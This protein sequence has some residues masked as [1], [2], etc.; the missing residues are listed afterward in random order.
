MTSNFLELTLL[1]FINALCVFFVVT[2]LANSL[3]D[4]QYRWFVT[5][6]VFL[7]G[8]VDFSYL[9]Y[10]VKN[11][12]LA[13]FFYQ[14]N[15]AFVAAFFFAAYVFY[16][17]YFLGINK[18]IFK[19]GVLSASI[20]FAYL[21]LITTTIIQGTIS[22]SWGNEIV[23]GPLN[24]SFNVFSVI[25]ASTFIYYFISRY[26][27]L[28]DKEKPKVLYFLVGTF[29]L[30][31]FNVIFN[32]LSPLIL[33]TARFQHFGDYSTII[34]L[35]FTAYA[36][37]K[38]QF[39][40][41][42]V[43]LSAFLISIISV[44]LLIDI[45][46][47]S[48]NLL[49]QGIK[50]IIFIFFVIASVLLLRSVLN[51]IRQKEEL[52]KVN[53]ALD[54]SRQSYLDL[55]TEQKDIID[56]MGHEIRT[57]LTAIVQE[58]KIHKKYTLPLEHELIAEAVDRPNLKKL[59]P[60]M[61]DTIKTVDRAST[62]AVSLVTDM[63]ETARLDKK[64]FELNYETFDLV[65]TVRSSV[66]LMS[67]TID[68]DDASVTYAVSFKEPTFPELLIEADKT[69]VGQAVYA[70]LNNAIKY[71]DP[72]KRTIDVAVSLTTK[73]KEAFITI[74][75]NGIGIAAEDIAKLGK[76]FLRLNP[77]TNSKLQRPGGTGLGLFVVKG[78]MNYHHGRLT[79]ASNGIGHGSSFTLELPM[80]KS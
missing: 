69:R 63:L 55:A 20:L 28:T 56:V 2:I 72:E 41:V 8:W 58:I 75:D 42:K 78:I 33:N 24:T 36:V 52:E 11:I 40:G 26:S 32:I 18:A 5:M 34:F 68:R 61:F 50:A 53:H 60:Y 25:M 35:S 37:L 30:I 38:Q 48:N 7:M 43:A 17:V 57:P 47:L 21:S 73:N 16:V 10:S 71:R 13:Q 1:T 70:L 51:E 77:K 12:A 15:W 76:K 3:K 62:Q 14:L 22:R 66:E 44:L 39:L 79:I 54:K 31:F 29:L 19:Y 45:L 27:K 46:T 49:E 67:K 59:L 74:H 80:Q 6:T 9:G 65:E 64:R 23:F 4:R